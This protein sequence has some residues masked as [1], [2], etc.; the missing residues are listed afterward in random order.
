MSEKNYEAQEQPTQAPGG[1]CEHVEQDGKPGLATII[2]QH[3]ADMYHEAL[4]RYPN[5]EAIDKEQERKLKRKLDMRILPLLGMCYF[6]YVSNC[7]GTR[8][9][10][11]LANNHSVC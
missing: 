9:L 7:A 6:F 4:R 10:A 2:N 11:T 5:D 1:R 3:N 8:F